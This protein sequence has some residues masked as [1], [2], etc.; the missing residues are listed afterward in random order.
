MKKI[1]TDHLGIELTQRCNLNCSH[2]FRGEARNVNISREIIEK[3][4]DEVKYARTLDLSGGEVF[5]AYDQLKMVLEIAKQKRTEIESCSML[6]NGTIYDERIYKLLEE[7]FGSN[8]QIS[9]SDDEYHQKSISRIY[10]K[11]IQESENPFL[12]PKT[13]G[14]IV[15]NITK[16]LEK[17]NCMGFRRVSKR[18]INNGRAVNLDAPHKDFEAYGYYYNKNVHPKLLFAGPMIFV[19]ADGFISDINSD[20][21][22]RSEQSLGNI[23]EHTICDLILNGGIEIECEGRDFF[24]IMTLRLLDFGAH[25]GNRLEFK[26]GKMCY[27][28]CKI[29]QEYETAVKELPSFLDRAYKA[30]Y[31]GKLNEFVKNDEYMKKY[32][33][34]LS[35]TEHEYPDDR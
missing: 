22:K 28:E 7:H 14:D 25:K 4:F 11:N 30:I 34:D 3:V 16:H 17:E 8:Y 18:L 6:T 5:L 13:I 32:P 19:G 26:N 15:K 12:H 23:N 10:G 21:D 27:K 33:K 2:C 29:D 31:G 24:N 20:L 35:K 9:I 1:L